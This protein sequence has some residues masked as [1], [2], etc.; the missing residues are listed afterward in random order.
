MCV[1]QL[2]ESS[3]LG[4]FNT[5]V[6]EKEIQLEQKGTTAQL[7]GTTAPQQSSNNEGD[8]AETDQEGRG[9]HATHIVGD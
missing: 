6:L 1:Q 5:P 7:E 8:Q 9:D 3:S 2:D 4:N